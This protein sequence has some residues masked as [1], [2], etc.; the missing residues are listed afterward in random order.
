MTPFSH[1]LDQSGTVGLEWEVSVDDAVI[2]A[3][4]S[5]PRVP[6]QASQASRTKKDDMKRLQ[7]EAR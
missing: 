5:T 1:D 3:H 6:S 7:E 2:R 4:Q